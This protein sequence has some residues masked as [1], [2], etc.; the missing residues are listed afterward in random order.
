MQNTIVQDLTELVGNTPLLRLS[1]FAPTGN[2]LVKLELLNPG[3]SV[4]DRIA[5]AMVEAAEKSGKITPGATLIE[6]TSGNTGIGLAWVAAVKRYKLILTMPESMSIERRKLL[7]ALGAEIVLTPGSEGMTGAMEKAEE[8]LQR[9]PGSFQPS[10]F[11]NPANPNAHYKTTGPEIWQACNGKVDILIAGVG[12]GGTLSG[13]GKFLKEKNPE[14]QI[15]AVEPTTSAVISGKAAGPHMIQGI[16]GGFIPDNLDR[17][18]LTEVFLVDSLQAIEA[19]KELALHEGLLAGISTGAN[20]WAARKVA[21][22]PENASKTVVTI[23]CDTGERYIS[24]LLFYH[25]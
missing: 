1:R 19:A 15:I 7:Q 16:G 4:K 12:T 20:V 3:S 23:A 24:T 18:I 10:Q 11:S 22:R 14:L 9:I 21:E 8:L 5:L 17:S 25:D 13:T 6:P 2:L